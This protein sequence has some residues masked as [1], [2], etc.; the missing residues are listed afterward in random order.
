VS[1]FENHKKRKSVM[2]ACHGHTNHLATTPPAIGRTSWMMRP[3]LSIIES[4][5]DAVLD[6]ELDYI[7]ASDAE[8]AIAA[9]EVPCQNYWDI[10]NSTD[11]YTERAD[12]WVQQVKLLPHP[13]LIQKAKTA[14]GVILSE[15]SE[16]VEALG[17]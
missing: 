15:K 1:L 5:I 10:R 13:E 6:E 12:E 14:I 3:D 11:S 16:L 17:R 2:G 9:I 7:D 4:A 8:E